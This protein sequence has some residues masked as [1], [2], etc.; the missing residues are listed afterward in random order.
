V[1]P[2]IELIHSGTNGLGQFYFDISG[3]SSGPFTVQAATNLTDW[4][5]IHTGSFPDTNFT[6]PA[7]SI[8][9]A[10]NYRVRTP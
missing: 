6:D 4:M 3:L 10:R 5:D 1:P 8:V 7:S 2:V 9:P